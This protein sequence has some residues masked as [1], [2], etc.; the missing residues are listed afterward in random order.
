MRL[1]GAMDV[2]GNIEANK[3]S[4]VETCAPAIIAAPE[5]P[6]VGLS[7]LPEVTGKLSIGRPRPLELQS[8]QALRALAATTVIFAHVPFVNR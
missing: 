4:C 2:R 5:G 6:T 1:G 3:P 7:E 8:I